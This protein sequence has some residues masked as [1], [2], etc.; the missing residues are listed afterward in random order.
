[1]IIDKTPDSFVGFLVVK[2]FLLLSPIVRVVHAI[3]RG[4]PSIVKHSAPIEIHD[5]MIGA[6][7]IREIYKYQNYKLL[8]RVNAVMTMCLFLL[9]NRSRFTISLDNAK[10][11]FLRL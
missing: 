6:L 11:V 3:P 8:R 4:S 9:F 5:K 10:A 1:M 7:I 2:W